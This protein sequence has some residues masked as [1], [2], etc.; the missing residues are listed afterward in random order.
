M[1][2][3]M[4]FAA[5]AAFTVQTA[6]ADYLICGSAQAVNLAGADPVTQNESYLSS[7]TISEPAVAYGEVCFEHADNGR[8]MGVSIDVAVETQG[9]RRFET[10]IP[11][12]EVVASCG[13][14]W[15]GEYI[16][17]GVMNIAKIHPIFWGV[18]NNAN[19]RKFALEYGWEGKYYGDSL[20]GVPLYMENAMEIIEVV[21]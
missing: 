3:P 7:R 15:C 11:Y 13:E 6:Q 19:R 17:D 4:I 12:T 1:N 8:L 18:N 21:W 2:I 9:S 20:T 16:M 5:V 14:A 10:F